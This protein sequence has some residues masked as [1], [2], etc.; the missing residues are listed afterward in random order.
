M[1]FAMKTGYFHSNVISRLVLPRHYSITMKM[2]LFVV[3]L[4]SIRCT[5]VFYGVYHENTV[6]F[7][8]I[9]CLSW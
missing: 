9:Q 7:V 3:T 1:L 4:W 5:V 8:V 2:V 6:S